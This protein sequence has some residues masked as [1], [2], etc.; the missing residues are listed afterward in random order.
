LEAEARHYAKKNGTYVEPEAATEPANA[1]K[2]QIDAVSAAEEG[3]EDEA[4][5][6]R[7]RIEMLEKF[8]E[9]DADDSS[10]ESESSDD[11]YVYI[12]AW[13]GCIG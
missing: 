9:V 12:A 2:R 1:P 10:S 8:R 11:E 13:L 6:K 7:R 3:A 5:Q 4:A